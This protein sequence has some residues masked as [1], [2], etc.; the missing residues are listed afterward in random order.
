M[1]EISILTPELAVKKQTSMWRLTFA[2]SELH[3]REIFPLICTVMGRLAQY[4][5][6]LPRAL[7]VK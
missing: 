5:Q 7:A 2:T 4:T 6:V 1:I 3:S